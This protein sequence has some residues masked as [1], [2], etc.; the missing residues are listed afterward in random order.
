MQYLPMP[1]TSAQD[2]AVITGVTKD[3]YWEP[4]RD[5][6]IKAYRAYRANAGSPFAI[7]PHDFGGDFADRQYKLYDTRKRGGPLGRMRRLP[8]L[9]SCPVC[10]SP[11]TGSLDHYLP[12]A[13]YPEFSIMR[14]NLMPACMHCNSGVKGDTVHGVGNER[15]IHPYFDHWADEVLWHVEFVAPLTAATFRAV[16]TAGMAAAQVDI[17]AFHLKNV[18]GDQFHLS[19]ANE[20]STYPL[21]IAIRR[22]APTSEDVI[23]QVNEDLQ[24]A[25]VS[26]GTNSWKAAFFRGLAADAE[27]MNHIGQQA[28]VIAIA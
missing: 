15:F 6:W 22:P 8:G 25:V 27:A 24:V 26:N 23:A 5:D 9:L 7:K 4:C 11:V 17:V 1:A 28:M 21:Q 16:P 2:E 20:W 18:L 19:L 3:I 13:V 12:R 14:A 10:G